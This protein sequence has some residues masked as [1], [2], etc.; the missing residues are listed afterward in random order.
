MSNVDKVLVKKLAALLLESEAIRML[1]I[2]IGLSEMGLDLGLVNGFTLVE[3]PIS[4]NAFN[5]MLH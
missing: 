4:L 1:F 2:E 3:A 5:E